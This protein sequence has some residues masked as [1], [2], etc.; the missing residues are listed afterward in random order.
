MTDPQPSLDPIDMPVAPTDS[1]NP[2][3][4]VDPSPQ[5]EVDPSSGAQNDAP[6][7]DEPDTFPRAYVE[8]L[9]EEN[10]R[11]R[12]RAGRAEEASRRL[13][14]TTVRSAAAN[15]L[16]DPGDLLVYDEAASLADDDG[17][18]D[19]DLIVQRAKVLAQDKP[20]LAARR[21]RGDIGQGASPTADTPN[22]AAMM[23]SRAI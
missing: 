23:R 22:L 15:I 16:A 20:H 18:P 4:E 14:E 2:Q 12:T 19:A 11:Y 17:W 1:G 3:P 9:R 13:M 8:Q 10:A 21:P 6:E 7:H 5:P